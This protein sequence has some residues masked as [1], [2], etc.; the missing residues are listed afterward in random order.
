VERITLGK[1]GLTVNRLGFGG[2]PIQRIKEE[3]A[4]N[5]VLHVL[6]RGTDF[7]D[8]ARSYSNS[9]E[10]IGKA[11]K[12]TAINPVMSSKSQQK[13]SDGIRA[14]IEISLSSL[15]TDMIDLYQCHLVQSEEDYKKIVSP[16]GALEG[17]IKAK[18]AGL[19]GHIG[20]TS[21]N[22][23]LL[24]KVLDDD[25]FETIMV[26]FS[27][28]EPAAE[29]RIIPKALATDVGVIIMKPFSGGALEDSR[30]A[31]KYV[32]S[33]PGTVIIPG[34]ESTKLFDKNWEICNG[35]YE[36]SDGEKREVE[37]IRNQF[38]KNFCRRCDYCQPCTE[39]IPIQLAL[40]LRYVVKRFGREVVRKKWMQEVVEKAR[41]CSECG[42][43]IKRCPYDL[44]VPELIKANIQWVD[45][46]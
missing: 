12:Q 36:L 6:N 13:T 4:I 37:K 42:E 1:T 28:L 8:T 9:E 44:P 18:Q 3:K 14:D 25:I 10:R 20:I 7:I 33:L 31:L 24:E 39:E 15:Q 46:I 16:G 19:I 29:E 22:L 32:L 35:S 41:R 17:M 43:C 27:F 38:D 5:T 21:H 26:C 30:L 45:E 2:I 34:I 40:G 23:D 11:L